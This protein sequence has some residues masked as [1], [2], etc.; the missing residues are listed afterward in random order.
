MVVDS[1]GSRQINRQVPPAK[2][3]LA[4]ESSQ[5]EGTHLK[6]CVCTDEGFGPPKNVRR[7]RNEP[8]RSTGIQGGR[9]KGPLQMGSVNNGARPMRRSAEGCEKRKKGPPS[10]EKSTVNVPAE[11]VK[12]KETFQKKA[13]HQCR[14]GK[15]KPIEGPI[16]YWNGG[17]RMCLEGAFA[18]RGGRVAEE[19]RSGR[20]RIELRLYL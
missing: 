10:G 3:V 8:T 13:R 4:R 5:G 19:I 9:K 2:K 18:G 14:K 15:E 17:G 6:G 11:R 12:A 1:K 7:E 16:T 20:T